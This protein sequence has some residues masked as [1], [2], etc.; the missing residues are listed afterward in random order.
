MTEKNEIAFRLENLI[1]I[2]KTFIDECKRTGRVD[3]KKYQGKIQLAV[4]V[5]I[6]VK[7]EDIAYESGKIREI[8]KEK[9]TIIG[10]SWLSLEH[11]IEDCILG[12][13]EYIEAAEYLSN[14]YQFIDGRKAIRIFVKKALRVL[15]SE[16]KD[17]VGKIKTNKILT[18][19]L[20]GLSEQSIKYGA[21]GFIY[22]IT[23]EM[24]KLQIN[25]GEVKVILR[26][27]IREDFEFKGSVEDFIKSQEEVSFVPLEPSAKLEIEFP[28]NSGRNIYSQ[29]QK[30]LTVLRLFK[31]GSVDFFKMEEYSNS[32]MDKEFIDLD[33]YNYKTTSNQY[34]SSVSSFKRILGSYNIDNEN[35][36]ALERFFKMIFYKVPLDFCDINV[37]RNYL[38]ISYERYVSAL[39]ED[40]SV[41]R[42]IATA[43]MGLE[44]IYLTENMELKYRLGSRSAR[45]LSAWSDEES[46]F[47]PIRIRS[48]IGLAYDIRS[49][50][51]HGDK[52][53]KSLLKKLDKNCSGI[54]HLLDLTL[55]YLRTS[56]CLCIILNVE[57]KEFV[58][59]I[60]DS[61]IDE[62]SLI[63][64]KR[65]LLSVTE[66]LKA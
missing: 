56:I 45:V 40:G 42:R 7:V 59:Q 48:L 24:E 36:P 60:D 43:V 37:S 17:A 6:Q 34:I 10:P 8:K 54:D 33:E 26:K 39:L 52:P 46:D 14:L 2:I 41:E 29:V 50:F 51:V 4:D 15:L 32:M 25:I 5:S 49:A 3:C 16:E 38:G 64:L 65:K 63:N 9:Q 21:K 1:Y 35:L 47:Y 27:L 23:L 20:D 44:S 61:M 11:I 62:T 22:G 57:K 58:S 13:E 28:D 19:F 66:L 30:T 31:V 55:N 53:D 12:F 18:D